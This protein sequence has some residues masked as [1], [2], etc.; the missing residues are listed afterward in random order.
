MGRR[1]KN[2]Y[3]FTFHSEPVVPEHVCEKEGCN[4][5]ADYRAPKDKSLT[6]YYWF[7]LEHVKEYNAQ[8]NYYEGMSTDEIEAHIKN[9]LGWQ[10][11]TW[12]LGEQRILSQMYSDPL[13][14][15]KEAFGEDE[16]AASSV[17]PTKTEAAII[18]AV[19]VLELT[20]PIERDKVRENYKRLA[21]TY[22]PD[23][24]G[25]D[26][27]A[28]EKFKHVAEAYRLVMSYLEADKV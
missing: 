23:S 9:D 13:G 28:E 26:K 21:K 25:G 6:D 8:W 5:A 20:F 3:D 22:H 12:K 4:C 19:Q 2:F 18:A 15:K 10:R 7:C 27:D 11:P 24:T 16:P 1:A 14:I 17:P